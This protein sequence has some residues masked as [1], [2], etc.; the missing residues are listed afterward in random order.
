M[1]NN[2]PNS[3]QVTNQPKSK[4][5]GKIIGFY[6]N[7]TKREYLAAKAMQGYLAN[8]AFLQSAYALETQTGLSVH[9]TVAFASI[10]AADALIEALVDTPLE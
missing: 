4:D 10:E 8:I 3:E 7:L 1:T 6:N 9:K 5:E 2:I